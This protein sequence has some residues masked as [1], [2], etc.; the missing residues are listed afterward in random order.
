MTEQQLQENFSTMLAI[1]P[2]LKEIEELFFKAV[3]SGA[4]QY[5]DEEHDS[6]RTAKIIY[7]AILSTMAEKWLP[8]LKENRMEAINLK[9]FL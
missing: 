9:K 4:L 5:I 6:Y 3:H 2:P 1:N 7:Y 8:L